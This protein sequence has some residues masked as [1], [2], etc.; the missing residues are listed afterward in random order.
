MA[1]HDRFSEMNLATVENEEPTTIHQPPVS[2]S[3]DVTGHE[4]RIA[5]TTPTPMS[6][7]DNNEIALTTGRRQSAYT[8]KT[9]HRR[10]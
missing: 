7:P 5:W 4:V 10:P 8:P 6:Q 9:N 3:L 1:D 2:E